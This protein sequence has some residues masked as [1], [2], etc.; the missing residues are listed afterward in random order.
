MNDNEKKFAD[1]ILCIRV[2]Y[3]SIFTYIKSVRLKIPRS[4][5]NNLVNDIIQ[6]IT[7]YSTFL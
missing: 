6:K 4:N 2:C 7:I 5:S 1:I 3:D